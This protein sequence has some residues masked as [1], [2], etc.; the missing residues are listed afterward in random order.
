[1]RWE[2]EMNWQPIE[3]APKDGTHIL[4]FEPFENVIV[5][6]WW[7]S[8]PDS[9]NGGAWYGT[10]PMDRLNWCQCFTHWMPLPSPP[11]AVAEMHKL[12]EE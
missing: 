1:M 7:W 4:A 6:T 2:N 12:M 3:T 9:K 10:D 5:S 8:Q 11:A